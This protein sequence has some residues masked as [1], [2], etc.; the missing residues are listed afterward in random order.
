M[1]TKNIYTIKEMLKEIEYANKINKLCN[2]SH[3][4]YI[5][6]KDNYNVYKLFY[7]W[8]SYKKF[9]CEY[10]QKEYQTQLINKILDLSEFINTIIINNIT[11]FIY[12]DSEL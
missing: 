1:N 12:L 3:K 2:N 6:L 8:K 9:I 4:N 11:Y 5:L 7:D 10:F